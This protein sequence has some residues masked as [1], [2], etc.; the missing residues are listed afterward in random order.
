MIVTVRMKL[1][2]IAPPQTDLDGVRLIPL[3]PFHVEHST[4]TSL[5]MELGGLFDDSLFEECRDRKARS[6]LNSY[7][8][9]ICEPKVSTADGHI[10][11]IC[12]LMVW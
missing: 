11:L 2:I 3:N 9:K 6:S 7:N 12:R 8:A 5:L 10:I 1:L 4:Y